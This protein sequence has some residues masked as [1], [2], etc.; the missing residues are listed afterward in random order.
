MSCFS[1]V[2]CFN[3]KS[4]QHQKFWFWITAVKIHTANFQISIYHRNFNYYYYCLWN[5]KWILRYLF[6]WYLWCFGITK[7]LMKMSAF[8]CVKIAN[9]YI[10]STNQ[11]NNLIDIWLSSFHISPSAH[12]LTLKQLAASSTHSAQW[13]C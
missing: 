4:N 7:I 8:D 12:E 3:R 13:F 2:K 5:S 1:W 10:Y 6:L 11:L 9:A